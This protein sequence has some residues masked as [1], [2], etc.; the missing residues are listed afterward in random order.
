MTIDEAI[1]KTSG[2]NDECL[3]PDWVVR[4]IE[5]CIPKDK[6]VWCPFDTEDSAF[7][8]VLKDKGH[9]VV[10]SHIVNGQDFF[11]YEP[12]E[13]GIIV[14][15]P[16]FTSKRAF[17]ERAFQLGKPFILLMTA[18]WLND[19]TPVKLYLKYGKEMQIIHFSKRVEFICPN[20]ENGK[21]PFKSLFFCSDVLP[22]G[23]VLIEV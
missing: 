19:S 2:K 3:T 4:A 1:Y 23:N 22:Q 5:P 12:E 7:V 9:K 18:Q 17:F 20:E 6:I 21:V 15:N 8:R 11:K 10:F 16:P 14:S 13:W